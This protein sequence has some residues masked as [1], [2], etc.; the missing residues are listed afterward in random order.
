MVKQEHRN[1]VCLHFLG[2]T[3][4][5][6]NALSS[7]AIYRITTDVGTTNEPCNCGGFTNISSVFVIHT[8]DLQLTVLDAMQYWEKYS[9]NQ[10]L[11]RT[12]Q[13]H[14]AHFILEQRLASYFLL[15][16]NLYMYR[17]IGTINNFAIIAS[18]FHNP[19]SCCISYDK[20]NLSIYLNSVCNMTVSVMQILGRLIGASDVDVQ[21]S[22]NRSNIAPAVC[23]STLS[24]NLCKPKSCTVTCTG[25]RDQQW[26]IIIFGHC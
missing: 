24:R 21:L 19:C 4:N 22:M 18:V 14:Y 17:Y 5:L 16:S 10:F 12:S 15:E 1:P 26:W 2:A 9:C 7:Y 23:P 20:N 25:G 3:S 8:G 13:M 6:S 11:P